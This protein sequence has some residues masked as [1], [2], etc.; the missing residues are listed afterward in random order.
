MMFFLLLLGK[1]F[2]ACNDYKTALDACLKNEKENKRKKNLIEA[3]LF[4]EKLQ[5]QNKK[6]NSLNKENNGI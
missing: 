3:R 2:G 1:W 6:M 4:E 5:L